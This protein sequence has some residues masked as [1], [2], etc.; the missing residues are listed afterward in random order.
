MVTGDCLP[1]SSLFW[2]LLPKRGEKSYLGCWM[3]VLSLLRVGA[4]VWQ[5]VRMLALRDFYLFCHQLY[6]VCNIC[7]IMAK[8]QEQLHVMY[9]M[10]AKG[11]E[12]L[13]VMMIIFYHY[14]NS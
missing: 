7:V 4:V 8:D 13:C 1:L 12:H 10:M 5:V 9:V 11:H 14:C 2:F 6:L 3:S